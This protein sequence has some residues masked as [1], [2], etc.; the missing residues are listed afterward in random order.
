M[1]EK[2][3]P[4]LQGLAFWIGYKRQLYHFY[5]IREGEIVGELFTLLQAHL[6]DTQR[7]NGEVMYK[8]IVKGWKQK[9]KTDGQQRVDIIISSKQ[10]HEKFSYMDDAECIIEVKRNQASTSKIKE[11]FQRIAR[12]LSL[13]KNRNLK[14]YVILVSHTGRP[15]AFVD[16]KGK[17]KR[18][19]KSDMSIAGM[20]DYLWHVKKVFKA[21]DKFYA[22]KKEDG[23]KVKT[24]A[25]DKAYYVC[26]IEIKKK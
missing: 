6:Y 2:L 13:T 12:C 26:L 20:P 7:L 5:D 21:V 11:D 17:A 19:N 24:G 14:G 1:N 3:Y 16:S 10:D 25:Y 18:D 22:Y 9:D 8:D 23:K 15:N 4:A